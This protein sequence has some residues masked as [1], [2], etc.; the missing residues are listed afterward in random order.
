MGDPYQ[1]YL[2]SMSS[3]WM[4]QAPPIP[5]A[6]LPTFRA[7]PLPLGSSPVGEF[8]SQTPGL[9]HDLQ[10][11]VMYDGAKTKS[12]KKLAVNA[13]GDAV[14]HR[15]TRSGCYTCRSRRVKVS[16]PRGDHL[17]EMLTS[18]QCDEK[19]PICERMLAIHDVSRLG[20]ANI[21]RLF[22]RRS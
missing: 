10:G 14:K 12:R 18:I 15:R 17:L 6:Q 11:P 7:S 9:Y 22:K 5:N 2:S 19:R 16:E 8:Y 3:V 13:S 21:L 20:R 1:H 4:Q